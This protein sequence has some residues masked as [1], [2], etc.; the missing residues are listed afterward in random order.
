MEGRKVIAPENIEVYEDVLRHCEHLS[1]GLCGLVDLVNLLHHLRLL[2]IN[3]FGLLYLVL[4]EE[5]H[6]LLLLTM[7]SDHVANFI[8][9]KHAQGLLLLGE[10]VR[11]G[12]GVLYYFLRL[13]WGLWRVLVCAAKSWDVARVVTL[14]YGD[15]VIA[16][17]RHARDIVGVLVLGFGPIKRSIQHH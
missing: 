12:L 10:W 3:K 1:G 7:H 16:E 8:D 6:H 5:P 15:V 13:L 4:L 9:E 14:V 11:Y 2:L 17:A